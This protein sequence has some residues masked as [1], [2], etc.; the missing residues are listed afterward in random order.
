MILNLH[1][2]S[3][4]VNPFQ[5]N[6][7]TLFSGTFI[8]QII[9]ILGALLLAKLYAPELYGTYNVFLSLVSILIIINTLK[10]EYII[11]TESSKERSINLISVLSFL[12]LLISLSYLLFFLAISS[13]FANKNIKLAV[14]L[15]SSI[16]SVFLSG[17]KIFE[18][19]AT[20]VSWFKEITY[21][22]VLMSLSTVSIQ[23]I[24]FYLYK[25][26]LIFGYIIALII[27]CTFYILILKSD[28][29]LPNLTLLK[30][31]LKNN[32]NILRFAFPSGFINSIGINIMPILLVSYFSASATGVYSLGLKIVSVPLFL[33]SS[34]VSQVFFQKA[35]IF[36]SESRHKLFSLTKKVVVSSLLTMLT[37]LLLINTLGLYIL[38]FIFDKHWENLNLYVLI[39][40]FYMICQSAFVPIS[41]LIVIVN[42]MHIGL[43][44]NLCLVLINLIAI[45][46]GNLY[47]NITYTVLILSVIGGIGYLV[48]L[49]YF[50]SYLKTF[51][52]EN[53]KL[54]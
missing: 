46:V 50:L 35:S 25:D 54:N 21:A 16:S 52:N 7:A 19:Y 3:Y 40:S 14:L 51:N 30:T 6:V 2:K 24:F 43:I 32:K 29:K 41:Y 53:Q 31:S 10:L 15:L 38:G 47:D 23:F 1:F 39:L 33:I 22:R 48:L 11:V 26:G 13:F 28:L 17:T 20:R 18:S 4:F 34:S 42:K 8:S 27:T 36:F 45:Y 9:N 37:A 44:F 5:K 49:F 12:V